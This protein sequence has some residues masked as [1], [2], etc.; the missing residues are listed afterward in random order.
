MFSSHLRIFVRSKLLSQK[1]KCMVAACLKNTCG[2]LSKQ[3]DQLGDQ[4][5]GK[6]CN[7]RKFREGV[8]A[9]KPLAPL[10]PRVLFIPQAQ[11]IQAREV[12][13]AVGFHRG[14]RR[15]RRLQIHPLL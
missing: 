3:T 5:L 9:D 10:R 13:Q 2:R 7:L 8:D 15:I 6:H 11:I 4:W 1:S 12:I 14:I